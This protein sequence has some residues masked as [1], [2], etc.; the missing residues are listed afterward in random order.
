MYC[1][2]SILTIFLRL[3]TLEPISNLHSS[4]LP[5]RDNPTLSVKNVLCNIFPN[6]ARIRTHGTTQ[7]RKERY[8]PAS[9]FHR[10]DPHRRTPVRPLPLVMHNR[11]KNPC[12]QVVHSLLPCHAPSICPF[13]QSFNPSSTTQLTSTRAEL[14]SHSLER[15]TVR[16]TVPEYIPCIF[17]TRT[18]VNTPAV[19]EGCQM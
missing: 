7:Q 15:S 19:V 2:S 6:R 12:R 16:S 9:H 17:R 10:Q 14:S 4:H 8:I 3:I 1:S 18:R 11:H 5:S 13:M